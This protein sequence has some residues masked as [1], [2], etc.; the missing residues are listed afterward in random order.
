M[1]DTV[2]NRIKSKG[3]KI[4]Y[5]RIYVEL[6]TFL[7]EVYDC[8]CNMV[9]TF[10]WYENPEKFKDYFYDTKNTYEYDL[11]DDN[12]D[13][14]EV[15][16]NI[17]K[18]FDITTKMEAYKRLEMGQVGW[19]KP[20]DIKHKNINRLILNNDKMNEKYVQKM[21]GA[22]FTPPQY[23]RISTQY[24]LNAIKNSKKD[25][26]D[27]YVII[28][29]CA[30]CGNLESQFDEKI[31]SHFILGT[32]N[33][34]EAF[35]AN[36]R[37]EENAIVNVQDALTEDGVK[38][39]QNQIEDYKKKHKV[40]KLAIIFLENPPYVQTNSNKEGGV[41]SKYEKTWVDK[42]MEKGG[43]DLD[44][45][46]VYSCFKYYDTYA[47]IH[48]GPI[49]IWK[50]RHLIDKEVIE[51]Y[52]CNMKYFNA[53]TSSTAL[54]HWKNVDKKYNKLD[55]KTDLH[56]SFIIKKV[57]STI[58]TLYKDDG[59]KNGVCVIEARNYSFKSPRLTGSINDGNE[60]GNKWVSEQNL[61]KVLPLFCVC[62][63]EYAEKGKWSDEDTEQNYCVMDTVYK[64]ADG[65]T[66]YQKDNKFLQD[67]LLYSMCTHFNHCKSK[68]KF[69][70]V[71]EKKLK[72][73]NLN[74]KLKKKIYDLYSN[75]VKETKLNGLNNIET[76]HKKELG[77]LWAEYNLFPKVRELKKLLREFYNKD[78]RPKMIKY[79][80][81][82]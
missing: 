13:L 67:C 38:F 6:K 31:Y 64:S 36:I 66:Q 76:F 75:L 29:R 77:K 23:I 72:K 42:Q 37:F 41:K 3:E 63:D 65:G 48:Y 61:L 19:F 49:K 73:N 10:D 82:K 59:K 15:I 9:D 54:I 16:Q 56:D 62:R 2:P 52:L 81:L 70:K 80:L 33:K 45:Q 69:F 4:P 51:C 34:A 20:F 46:F 79:E 35:T 68:S 17:Y 24:V 71:A 47:Y 7:V 30:G 74:T 25:G 53:G 60:H 18:V 14:V 12:V 43:E 1:F 58:S 78:I 8:H 22:F 55:F 26:Y 50:S 39:Y 11:E 32:I 44:E 57:N 40:K 21:E 28:D 5:Y 27:D